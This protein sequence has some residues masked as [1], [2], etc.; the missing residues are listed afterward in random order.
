ME[1]LQFTVLEGELSIHRLPASAPVPDEVFTATF[2]SIT[3]TSEE[4]SIVCP[5][6]ININ[7][8]R[9]E[10][11]WSCIKIIGPLEFSQTGVL[12]ALST[13]LARAGIA[14]FVISTFDTD[15]ILVKSRFLTAAIEQLAA[16][17]YDLL[18]E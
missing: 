8:A 16:A 3:R 10:K 6:D 17:G 7:G 14:I 15:Y 9:T 13:S 12:A 4:L 18:E 11:G 1:K 5:E 2:Y